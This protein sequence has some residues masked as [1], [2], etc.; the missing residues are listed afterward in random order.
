MSAATAIFWWT[1][2]NSR[3]PKSGRGFGTGA[4]R[5]R[6]RCRIDG[7]QA[8]LVH[9]SAKHLSLDIPKP[10]RPGS[11]ARHDRVG[12][13][14]IA[15]R[16]GAP[17]RAGSDARAG[18]RRRRLAAMVLWENASLLIGGLGIGLVA[19]LVSIIPQLAAGGAT[20][21]GPGSPEPSPSSSSLAS[22]PA[23]PPSAS[24]SAAPLIP[25]LRGS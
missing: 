12:R 22:S 7:R 4:W 2:S 11:F 15:Q 20:I 18:F 1:R 23:S 14:S 3:R 17:R 24:P 10:R 6:F 8:G 25:A 19:A 5:L 16:P 9:G 13:R 21:P